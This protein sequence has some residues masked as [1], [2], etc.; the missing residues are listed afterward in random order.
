MAIHRVH[1]I[2]TD[3]RPALLEHIVNLS[4]FY[5]GKKK[6]DRRKVTSKE[7]VPDVA[8]HLRRRHMAKLRELADFERRV[9]QA[10]TLEEC[11]DDLMCSMGQEPAICLPFPNDDSDL[12]GPFEPAYPS[13]GSYSA[14]VA[15]IKGGKWSGNAEDR[16]NADPYAINLIAS[17][18][19]T[20]ADDLADVGCG[21]IDDDIDICI[22][23]VNIEVPNP[24]RIICEIANGILSVVALAFATITAQMDYQ[25]ALVDGAEIEAAF[26]NS[27]NILNKQC[28]IYDAV[29][30][31]CA[32]LGVGS[33]CDGI[34]SDCDG[35]VVREI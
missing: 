23:F 16:T 1:R 26:E 10:T 6:E 7:K 19:A 28:A 22:F 20:I 8:Q 9:L 4:E 12:F 34:D 25:D 14:A 11:A 27:N 17:A 30:C 33:G 31:R 32:Q 2:I 13:G 24:F 35:K 18:A 15:S 29:E 21:A 5:K 3:H